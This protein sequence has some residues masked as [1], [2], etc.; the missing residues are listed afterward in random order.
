MK[1]RIRDLGPAAFSFQYTEFKRPL[2]HQWHFV[3]GDAAPA[4]WPSAWRRDQ[5]RRCF[6]NRRS[7][8]AA[9]ADLQRLTP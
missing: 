5:A 3:G 6:T 8:Q 2:P 4:S 1:T 7:V 9:L